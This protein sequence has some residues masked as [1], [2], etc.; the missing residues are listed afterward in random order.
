MISSVQQSCD[1]GWKAPFTHPYDQSGPL[2]YR[3]AE[4]LVGLVPRSRSWLLAG[5]FLYLLLMAIV[6]VWIVVAE[7]DRKVRRSLVK[8]FLHTLR[9]PTMLT[10]WIFVA[11]AALSAFWSLRPEAALS[12]AAQ[13]SFLLIIFALGLTAIFRS[14]AEPL[15]LL[16]R[17]SV[18]GAAIGLAYLA[19]E[20]ATGGQLKA[21][22]ANTTELTP[23][24]MTFNVVENGQVVEVLRTFLNRHSAALCI[25]IFRLQPVLRH[26]LG[27]GLRRTRLA[28]LL[29]LSTFALLVMISESETA[30]LACIT[31]LSVF[32]LSWISSR[33]AALVLGAGWCT[34]CLAAPL[35]VMLVFPTKFGWQRH[36]PPTAYDRAEIWRYTGQ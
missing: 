26:G 32:A 35:L 34:A 16:A 6:A 27:P 20:H 22:V 14:R 17:G 2:R 8:S 33:S 12:K 3:L 13:L 15:W 19:I 29:L 9:R 4:W 1:L 21:F 36:L 5:L 23:R 31:S 28:V 7:P 18:H 25:L 30:K 11:Y 10:L 24:E